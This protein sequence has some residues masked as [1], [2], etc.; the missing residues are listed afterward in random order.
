MQVWKYPMMGMLH[1]QFNPRTAQELF[2]GPLLEG[3]SCED[4]IYPDGAHLM[5]FKDMRKLLYK[6]QRPAIATSVYLFLLNV[7]FFRH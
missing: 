3:A 7:I 1:F 5:D 2:I 4:V 6:M